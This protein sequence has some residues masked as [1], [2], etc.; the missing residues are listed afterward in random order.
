MSRDSRVLHQGGRFFEG[1]RWHDDRWYV[2]DFFSHVVMELDER[3]HAERVLEV[4]GQPSGLGWLPDESLVVVS[5]T[6]QRLLRRWPDGHVTEHADVSAHCGGWAND[7]VVDGK[8]R[9]YVG[10]FGFPLVRG[11]KPVPASLILVELDGTPAV[12]ADDLLFPNGMV[13]TPDGKTLVVGETFRNRYTAFTIQPDG[14]LTDRRI[15]VDLSATVDRTKL[16]P[17]G[18]A[19]D[20]N[21]H[22]WSADAALGQLHRIAPDGRV[23][24]QLDPPQGLKFF[25]CA[26][27]GADGRTL[28]GCAARGYLEAQ[29]S[30]SLDAV[31]TTTLV[32]SPH[33]GWP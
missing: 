6:D 28:L 2:S 11:F 24:E 22:I 12:V 8:G 23:L 29:E 21:L 25:A 3:G 27:G 19:L 9:A 7:M 1:A 31:L 18:C 30:E 17:D 20:A 26:L 32:D 5:M 33:A 10:N 4:A 13:I 15:W 16:Q 14:S